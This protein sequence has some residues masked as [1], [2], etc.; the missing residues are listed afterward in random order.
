[1]VYQ[2]LKS[3]QTC[4]LC[5]DPS[6]EQPIC[7][8]CELELPWLG[9]HCRICALPLPVSG[10]HCGHCLRHPPS[11][12]RV[13]APW[14]FAFP[15][16]SLIHRFKHRA[17]WPCGRILAGQL[18]Q[19]LEHAYSE[20]L[21]RPDLLLPVPLSASRLQAR[22]FNQ[23]EMLGHWLSRPLGIPCPAHLLQRPRETPAQQQ[24]GARARWRNLQSAFALLRPDALQHQHVALV[25]DVMT[26]GATAESLARL[27]IHAG[28]RRVDLYCLARTPKPGD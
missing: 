17:D 6:P 7:P 28:A 26:T 4:L 5:S 10:Q 27:L 8:P 14:R 23:A 25:D 22:G 3:V 13:E 12:S 15:V 21:E 24:L 1:M 2:W 20:G 11:F 9:A 16:D 18:Q 19:H